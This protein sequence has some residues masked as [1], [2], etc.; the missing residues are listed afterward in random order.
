MTH[1]IYSWFGKLVA[2]FETEDLPKNTDFFFTKKVEIDNGDV[3]FLLEL[4]VII[5]LSK[6]DREFRPFWIIFF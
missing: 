6:F 4:A 1:N 3:V 2:R 5:T